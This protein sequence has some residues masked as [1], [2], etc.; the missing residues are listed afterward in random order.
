[1]RVFERAHHADRL[2]QQKVQGSRG[3]DEWTAIDQDA[4]TLGV[5]RCP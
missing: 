1:L 5:Y 3:K 2:V 4:V